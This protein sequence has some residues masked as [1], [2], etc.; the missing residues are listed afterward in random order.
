MLVLRNFFFYPSR[1]P[2]SCLIYFTKLVD[3]DVKDILTH[4]CLTVPL[5]SFFWTL[6]TYDD[7][8]GIKNNFTKYLKDTCK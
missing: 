4:S 7:N 5:E 6:D 1:R 2:F 3:P 8:F